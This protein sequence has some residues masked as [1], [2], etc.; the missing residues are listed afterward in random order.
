MQKIVG[1]QSALIWAW[2]AFKSGVQKCGFCSLARRVKALSAGH[3]REFM[4]ATVCQAAGRCTEVLEKMFKN[5]V[6][7]G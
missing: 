4:R 5:A 3:I 2:L 7:V 1:G 6:S